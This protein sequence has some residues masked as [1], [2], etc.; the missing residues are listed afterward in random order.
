MKKG[1]IITIAIVLMV[2][3]AFTAPVSAIKE[4]DTSVSISTG[5]GAAPIIKCKWEST[6]GDAV[7]NGDPSHLIPGT[8]VKAPGVYEGTQNINYWA[9]AT[10]P[11]GAAD[12]KNVHAM[13]YHP[14]GSFKYKVEM[15]TK[16]A[17][18]DTAKANVVAAY[19]AGL[20]VLNDDFTVAEILTELE[21]QDAFLWKGSEAIHYCQP[22]GDYE[23]VLNAYDQYNNWAVP[24]INTFTYL[25]LPLCEF[26]FLAV[27]YKDVNVGVHTWT[28]G[29][30]NFGTADKPTVRNIGNVPL[31][32]QVA[33]DDM[34]LGIT[35]KGIWNVHYDVRLGP[36]PNTVDLYDPVHLKDAQWT[37]SANDYFT[38]TDTLER[39]ITEKLDFSINIDQGRS[40]TYDGKIY[41]KCIPVPVC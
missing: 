22:A 18:T 29:D 27:S 1:F 41:L 13:V 19:D 26:D 12:V 32:I 23:V 8:Q 6:S 3:L 20:L 25:D 17:N 38:M 15:L 16:V 31:K 37:P 21:Q 40:G 2:A 5:G 7:E 30:T 4:A 28:G 39:C 14:D 34:G 33:Q 36:S 24:L 35:S 10:D 11:N 9:V